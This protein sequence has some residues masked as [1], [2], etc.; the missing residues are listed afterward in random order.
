M[1]GG[2][3]SLSRLSSFGGHGKVKTAPSQTLNSLSR[4]LKKSAPLTHGNQSLCSTRS[5]CYVLWFACS[6][7]R[8]SQWLKQMPAKYIW[9]TTV[10]DSYSSASRLQSITTSLCISRR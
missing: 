5:F 8:R 2:G 1:N 6:Q 4:Q 9:Q 10:S 7:Q 3:F